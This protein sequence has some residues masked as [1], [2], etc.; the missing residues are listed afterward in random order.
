MSARDVA[1]GLAAAAWLGR[2]RAQGLALLEGTPAAAWRSF[3]ALV[4]AA[5]MYLA[6]KLVTGVPAPAVHDPLR[7]V[8]AEAIGYVAGWFATPLVMLAVARVLDRETRWPLFVAAWNWANVVQI[9][10]FLAASAVAG[11]L[12][13]GLDGVATLAAFGY[14]L[15]LHWFVARHALAI[16]GPRAAAVVGI[17]L[18]LG[19]FLSGVTLSLGLA[20]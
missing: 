16:P 3:V 7:L 18:T 10:V 4:V 20:R 2:G 5:P 12:P 13:R 15:W 9:A 11:L 19:L 6:L 17:D 1:A 8:A 14:A